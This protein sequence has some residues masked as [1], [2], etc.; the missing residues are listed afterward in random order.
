MAAAYLE[1]ILA[2]QPREEY[3]LGGHSLGAHI[4]FEMAQQL[5]A[6]GRRVPVLAIFDQAPANLSQL[7]VPWT[8]SSLRNLAAGLAGWWGHLIAED[9]DRVAFR[10]RRRLRLL[11]VHAARLL[12]SSRPPGLRAAEV[13]DLSGVSSAEMG[14]ALEA[15]WGAAR[16]YLPRTYDGQMILFRSRV[17]GVFACHDSRLGWGSLV[18]GGVAVVDIP[19]N[20]SEILKEPQAALVARALEEQI[21]RGRPVRV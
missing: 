8:A 19:G 16:R 5:L 3:L 18:R 12:G 10:L 21:A 20:H 1:E 17:Q 13:V 14:R 11:Q 4:A 7:R 15:H 2:L 9:R 6:Q